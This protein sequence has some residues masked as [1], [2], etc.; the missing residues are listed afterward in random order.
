MPVG[1]LASRVCS[2]SCS[3]SRSKK[4]DDGC[5]LSSAFSSAPPLASPLALLSPSEA[6]ARVRGAQRISLRHGTG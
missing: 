1:W 5:V 6:C 2:A 3:N 4:S